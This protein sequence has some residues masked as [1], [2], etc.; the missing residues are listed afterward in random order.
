MGH[1]L[2]AS[3]LMS[4][5]VNYPELENKIKGVVVIGYNLLFY[6]SLNNSLFKRKTELQ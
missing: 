6:L 1:S 5:V 4:L 3:V 2:G